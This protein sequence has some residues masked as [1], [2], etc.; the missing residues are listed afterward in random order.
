MTRAE[1]DRKL[2]QISRLSSEELRGWHWARMT[3]QR[4]PFPGETTAILERQ[5]QLTPK[6]K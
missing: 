6:A 3:D 5:R 4:E 2:A 1:I